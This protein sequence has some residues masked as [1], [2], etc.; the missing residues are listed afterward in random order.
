MTDFVDSKGRVV[1]EVMV[2]DIDKLRDQ[3]V[4]EIVSKALSMRDLLAEFKAEI[5]SDL[6]SYLSLSSEQYGKKYGGKKGNVTLTSYDSSLR[7]ILSAKESITFDERLQIAKSIIDDCIMRWA[8][9]SSN[10]IIS[11]VQDA[12]YV[13]KAGNIS[14]TRI[15]GLRRLA[16]QDPE[17]LRAMEA[18]SDSI[19][20]SGS[21]EYLRIYT[22]DEK[23]GEY[24]Q[25]PLDISAL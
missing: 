23:T 5:R 8:K 2:S 13:D 7:I 25:V 1:P 20:V 12:F 24:K 19:Q 15:L 4:R 17:W 3:T 6:M 9:G 21:K 18:I 16:I 22:R 10:E 14:T 11:L